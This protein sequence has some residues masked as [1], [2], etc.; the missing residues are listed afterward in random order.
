MKNKDIILFI[1]AIC[2]L[3]LILCDNKKNKEIKDL[4]E[5]FTNNA[6]GDEGITESIKNLGIIAGQIRKANGDFEF[7]ANLKVPDGNLDVPGTGRFGK[8]RIPLGGKIIFEGPGDKFSEMFFNT[9]VDGLE[10]AQRK[11]ASKFRLYQDNNGFDFTNDSITR[12]GSSKLRLKNGIVSDNDIQT[13]KQFKLI[14]NN[15]NGGE[16]TRGRI[17]KD[18]DSAGT[19]STYIES[20]DGNIQ[21]ENDIKLPQEKKIRFGEDEN[22]TIEAGHA[23][24]IRGVSNSIV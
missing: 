13:K 3:Y 23:L 12:V 15:P 6:T 10:I 18:T 1:L 14:D 11:G 8:I 16:V 24:Y 19:I 20:A 5:S 7:P 2:V 22:T 4:K 17:F 21:F 9:G